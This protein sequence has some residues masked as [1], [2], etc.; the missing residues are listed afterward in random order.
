[1]DGT[2]GDV[3]VEWGEM[4]VGTGAVHC[5]NEEGNMIGLV[6]DQVMFYEGVLP[7]PPPLRTS[8]WSATTLH[9]FTCA[10]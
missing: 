8:H 3:A 1:M 6:S 7:A 9:S 10:P 5:V 4:V 2:A